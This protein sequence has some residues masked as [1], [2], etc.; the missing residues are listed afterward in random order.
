MKSY[1]LWCVKWVVRFKG[2]GGEFSGESGQIESPNYPS[3][4]YNNMDCRWIITTQ[5]GYS[6]SLEIVYFVLEGRFDYLYVSSF[7]FPEV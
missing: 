6:V 2:C 3:N 4:Y 7:A 1:C 5:E